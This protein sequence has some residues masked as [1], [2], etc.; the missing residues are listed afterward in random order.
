MGAPNAVTRS[1]RLDQ[2]E[3]TVFAEQGY[4]VRRAVFDGPELEILGEACE[5]VVAELESLER[6]PHLEMGAY[7]FE[8]APTKHTVIKWEK[9]ARDTVLGIEPAAH[10]HPA[11]EECARDPRLVEPMRDVLGCDR[12]GLYTEKL[13]FKRAR[14]GG[15]IALHQDYPY[16]VD[17]AD[18]PKRIATAVLFLDAAARGNGCLEVA[19]GSHLKGVQKLKNVDGFGANEIDPAGFDRSQL[20]ALEVPAGSVVFLGSLLVHRSSPNSSGED[21][22]ALLYSYQPAG[23]RHS[24][25][26][27]RIDAERGVQIGLPAGSEPG[28]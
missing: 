21:R 22:R 7:V 23:Y 26:Y 24:R 13:N 25:E 12:V 10:L 8:V 14:S 6:A 17:V 18:D 15:P 3:Q 11:L 4:L 20:V 19:P 1:L 16:W 27:I 5:R 9:A 2:E 28:A